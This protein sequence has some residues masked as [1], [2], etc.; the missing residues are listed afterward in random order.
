VDLYF[1]AN[2]KSN[3]LYLNNGDWT[4][5]RHHRKS[6]CG[7]TVKAGLRALQWRMSME[8]GCS[9]STF[10][11]PETSKAIAAPTNCSLTTETD[12]YEKKLN[13]GVA[14]QGLSTHG[15]FFDYDRDGDLDLYVLNNSYRAIGSFNLEKAR[16]K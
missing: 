14:D 4:F 1:T 15:V 7:W 11:I 13:M 12:L 9:I 3:K 10:L 5:D 8:T 16:A 2:Q 6:G